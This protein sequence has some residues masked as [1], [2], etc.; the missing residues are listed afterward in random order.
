MKPLQSL[1]RHAGSQRLQALE[2]RPVCGGRGPRRSTV[3]ACLL[4]TSVPSGLHLTLEDI[5][6]NKELGGSHKEYSNIVALGLPE[7]GT[8]DPET[9]RSWRWQTHAHP[10]SIPTE[11]RAVDS[12]RG[13]H[14][15]RMVPERACACACVRVVLSPE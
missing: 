4:V 2:G 12:E 5:S 7:G 3:P 15:L 1:R 14:K 8:R 13:G 6:E 9:D 11:Q 10:D